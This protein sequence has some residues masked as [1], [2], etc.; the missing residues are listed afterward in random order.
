MKRVKSPLCMESYKE[1]KEKLVGPK[2]NELM[3]YVTKL[4]F[5]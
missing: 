4:F 5:L 1:I 3:P 2:Y